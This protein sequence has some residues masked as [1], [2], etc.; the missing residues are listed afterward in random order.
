MKKTIILLLS[1]AYLSSCNQEKSVEERYLY[2]EDKIVDVE[3]GDEYLMEED[4]QI[5]VLHTDGSKEK[6]AIDETPFYGSALSDEYIKSLEAKLTERKEALLEEKKNQLKEVRKSRY[7]DFSDEEL[8]ERFQQAHK[9]GLDMSRQMDMIAELVERGVVSS[10]DAPDLLEI[11]PEM[12]NFEI[13]ID[14]NPE[15]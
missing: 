14:Q 5:T 3:T 1:I 9:D 7:V 2:Q 6:I 15:N 8:L 12:V 4:D 11:S 10:E 13:E